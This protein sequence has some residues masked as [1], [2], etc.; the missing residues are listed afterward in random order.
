[1]N[2][3]A[4]RPD[5]VP[6]AFLV[7]RRADG[8]IVGLILSEVDEKAPDTG[9][10]KRFGG[11]PCEECPVRRNLGLHAQAFPGQSGHATEAGTLIGNQNQFQL[12]IQFMA[13]YYV[14]L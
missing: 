14:S 7:T 10:D 3:V 9:L 6:D 1:V 12:A 4:E 8:L 2:D 13:V 5:V 11:F